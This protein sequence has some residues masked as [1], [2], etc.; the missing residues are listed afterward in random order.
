MKY[1]YACYFTDNMFQPD[2]SLLADVINP[3]NEGFRYKSLFVIDSGVLDAHPGILEHIEEYCNEHGL[4]Y[5]TS[6][7]IKGGED[8]KNDPE[9][10]DKILNAINTE[11][12]CRHSYL[13]A[14]GGGA[15]LDLAGYSAGIAHRGV[16]IIR[17]PTTVLAQNDAGVGVKNGINYF[18]KKNFTGTF[19]IPKAII[20]D[21]TFLKTLDMRDWIAGIAEAIKVA[22]LQDREFFEVIE[23]N[24]PKLQQGDMDTM[25]QL[26][27]RCAEMHMAHISQNGDPF[28]SGSSRPLDFGHWSAHKLEQITNYRIRHGEA[29]AI[30]LA[31]DCT[32]AHLKGF[33]DSGSLQR[34]IN[35]LMEVGFDLSI[36]K[37][38]Q[39]HP[40]T[41]LQGL[42]EFRE[43]LGGELTI[44]LIEG[45]GV[46]KDVHTI[47]RKLMEKAI[48]HW[49]N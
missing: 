10:L 6:L 34:I 46:Q 43:H 1:S 19:A 17:V 33:L 30:G 39:I 41:L 22:L 29:V 37:D 7:A 11:G 27:H 42:E 15:L 8:C 49:L 2:N 36:L 25:A 3:G 14:I 40:P 38:K 48:N 31:I 24:A 20:N 26:I 5:T 47:D 16:Q 12:I 4:N 21:S 28:E 35:T 13:I 45:I 44:T 18:G 23:R 9:Y 32:Y